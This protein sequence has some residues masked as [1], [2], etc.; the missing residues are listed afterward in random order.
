MKKN[1]QKEKR[2]KK[3]RRKARIGARIRSSKKKPRLSIFRSNYHIWCQL[4]DDL[5]GETLISASSGELPSKEKKE[6]NK[7]RLAYEVGRLIAQKSLKAG[8]KEIV[9]DK[10]SYQYHG[11]IESLAKGAREGGLKF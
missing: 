10:G 8:I 4:I 11:R 9:F 6:K 1:P 2:I 3:M 5:K 7:V